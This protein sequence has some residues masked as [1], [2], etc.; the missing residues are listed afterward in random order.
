[1]LIDSFFAQD[2][3]ELAVA[4]LGKVL[5]AKYRGRWLS[6]RIVETEAYYLADK[7]SHS[8]KGYTE[9]RKAMFMAPGTIYMY[10]SRGGDSMNISA[11]GEGNAVLIKSGVP[12]M[13]G[14][15][16]DKMLATMQ[17][18]HPRRHS[19]V[20]REVHRQCAGQTLLCQSLGVTVK[21]WDQKAFDPD[22]LYLDEV[23]YSPEQVIQTRRL[24]IPVGQDEHLMYRFIDFA[25]VES[26]TDNPLRKRAYRAGK[27]YRII[28]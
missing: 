9:K 27:D 8:S 11:R 2:A 14:E 10:Y 1:M 16:S 12:H 7:S 18:L 17:R 23:G 19:H 28:E 22:R 25:A 4:L 15:G 21:K 13:A 3:Q 24:G 20:P 6:A 5:R 26:C